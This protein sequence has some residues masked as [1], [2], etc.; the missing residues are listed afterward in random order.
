MLEIHRS[1][2]GS[3]RQKLAAKTGVPTLE[4]GSQN[5][6]EGSLKHKLLY[7]N[8]SFRFSWSGVAYLHF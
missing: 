7:P 8:M 4:G 2:R 6:P 5:L 1:T 3:P